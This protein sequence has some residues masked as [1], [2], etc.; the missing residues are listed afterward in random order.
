MSGGLGAAVFVAAIVLAVVVHE[1]GHLVTAKRFGMRADRFFVGF[2]PTLFSRRVGETVYG[3]KA[4]L[5]GGYV[6]VMGMSPEDERLA[7]VGETLA[8]LAPIAEDDLARELERELERRGT[9]AALRERIAEVLR[10]RTAAGPGAAP[11]ERIDGAITAA[12]GEPARVGDLAWRLLRGD[13]G[14]FFPERPAWQRAVVLVTGPLSHLVVAFAVLAGAYAAI[15]QPTGE[16]TSVVAQVVPDSPAAEAGLAAGDRIVAVG[17]VRS[18]AFAALREELR[19]RPGRATAFVVER[20][21]VEVV[22]E[23]VPRAEVDP[24]TGATVGVA[25]FLPEPEFAPLRLTE[26]VTRAAV[27]EPSALSPGGVGP[28]LTGSAVGLVRI[29][30]PEGLVGLV[31]QAS[32]IEERAPDGA[33]SLVGAAGVAGQLAD[34]G[35]YGLTAFLALIAAVNVFFALFNLVPLP[36]FDGGHLAVLTIERTVNAVRARRGRPADFTVDPRTIAAVAV[37]VIAVLGL[38]LVTT[39]WLDLTDPI[40]LG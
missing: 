25:G 4:L 7:P 16:V 33:V 6:R 13:E 38:L 37:P 2:G 20:D 31:S 28:M 15:D 21:G 40:R 30:S 11:A 27:G 3:V 14:R 18:D 9:P 39:L 35:P 10:A 19:A 29:L 8:A 32:G 12:V 24:D 34:A 36:P 1:L 5:L 17:D 22:L 23:L 26:A